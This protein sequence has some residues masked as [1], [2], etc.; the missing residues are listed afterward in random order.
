MWNPLFEL[1]FHEPVSGVFVLYV[2]EIFLDKIAL[3]L[4]FAL[5]LLCFK[6]GGHDDYE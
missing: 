5:D 1:Q 3:S 4:H 2:E 6:E